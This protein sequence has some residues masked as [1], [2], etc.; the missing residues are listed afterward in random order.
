MLND[1]RYTK[2]ASMD[3]KKALL[4]DYKVAEESIMSL[5]IVFGKSM[6]SIL[7]GT[8]TGKPAD[9]TLDFGNVS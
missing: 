7:A 3:I 4:K 6:E 2:D 9:A 1:K 8:Y 5:M